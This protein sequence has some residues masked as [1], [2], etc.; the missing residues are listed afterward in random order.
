[1]LKNSLNTQNNFADP[2]N[3]TD[4]FS[5]V[6]SNNSLKMF[7]NNAIAESAGSYATSFMKP[8]GSTNVF[9]STLRL[10]VEHPLDPAECLTI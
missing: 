4:A 9:F 10:L 8:G 3:N 5:S 1:M 7:G 6:A 2:T